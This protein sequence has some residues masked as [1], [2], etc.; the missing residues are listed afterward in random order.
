MTKHLLRYFWI[1]YLVVLSLVLPSVN[2]ETVV[3]TVS[4][5]ATPA[6]LS[7]TVTPQW[8]DKQQKLIEKAKATLEKERLTW[9]TEEKSFPKKMEEID[10]AAKPVTEDLLKP[11]VEAKEAASSPVEKLHSERQLTKDHLEKLQ[12]T[13]QEQ[14]KQLESLQASPPAKLATDTP[15]K[16]SSPATAPPAQP[17]AKKH[18]NTSS[19]SKQENARAETA[20]TPAPKDEVKDKPNN[21]LAEPAVKPEPTPDELKAN[22]ALLQSAIDIQ[23]QYL[24]VL[25]EQYQIASQHLKLAIQWH[26]KLQVSIQMRQLKEKQEAIKNV[27]A[28]LTKNQESFQFQQKELPSQIARLETA[29]ITADA[30]REMLEKA[31]LDKET[32][33]IEIDNLKLENQGA[34]ANLAKQ[35]NDIEDQRKKLE[36]LRKTALPEP[37]QVEVQNQIIAGQENAIKLQE[38]RLELDKQSFDLAKQSLEQTEKQSQLATEWHQKLQTVYQQREQQF[39]E[40]QVQQEQQRHLSHALELRKQ[41]EQLPATAPVTQRELL[42]VQIQEAKERAEQV[43]RQLQFKHLEA[44]LQQWQTASQQK[45]TETEI[46]Q[47]LSSLQD[48]LKNMGNL[49]VGLKELQESLDSKVQAF[50]QQLDVVKKKGETL[51]EETLLKYNTQSQQILT[52]LAGGLR[53]ELN[54]IP[55]LRSKGEDLQKQ[56]ESTYK[57]TLGQAL[58]RVRQLP[59]DIA[60]WRILFEEGL[61]P[62]PNLFV[63]QVQLTW[64]GFAQAFQQTTAQNW[65]SFSVVTL[66]WLLFLAGTLRW[67]GG[68]TLNTLNTAKE[69]SFAAYGASL[70]IRLLQRNVGSIAIAGVVM[71]LLWLTKPTW[72]HSIFVLTLVTGWLAITLL[73]NGVRLLLA[74]D[75]LKIADHAKLSWELQSLFLFLGI[76]GVITTLIHIDVEEYVLKVSL[77][78]SDLIDT[79]F[80]LG[81]SLTV[82]PLLQFRKVMLNAWQSRNQSSGGV[83]IHLLTLIVPLLILAVALLGLI[84]YIN[85][86]WNIAKH[87]S[88]FLL[89]LIGWFIIWGLVTDAINWWK[90]VATTR[91]NNALWTESLIPLVHKILGIALVIL[92]GMA[93]SW[94]NGWYADVAVRQNIVGVLDFSLLKLGGQAITVGDVLL[95]IFALWIV[96]WLGGWSRQVTYQ[97]VYQNVIDTGV[98]HSLSVFTQYAV[99]LVGLLVTLNIIGINL[100]TLTVFAGAVGV[101]IGF[102]LQNVINNFVSG[103]LLLVERPLR[104]GD[105]V[106]ISS[107]QGKVVEIGIRS[108]TLETPE[109]QAVIVP[110]SAVISQI[111]INWTRDNS[112]RR[113]SL[114]V[115][116]DFDDNPQLVQDILTATLEEN[117]EVRKQPAFKVYLSEYTDLAMKFRIDYFVDIR[118]TNFTQVNST[119][120]I[121]IWERFRVAGI[122][123]SRQH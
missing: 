118:K 44:Q 114:Y 82:L 49:F 45:T 29:Q 10:K 76:L 36:T 87:L 50:E 77:T 63:Q 8:L 92:A 7:T 24:K 28:E 48:L 80:M 66:L 59:K 96:F 21:A 25:D 34:E 13:L 43:K 60:G 54:K 22:I 41:L 32:K 75:S 20:K 74:D 95:G 2:A 5:P 38:Q 56:L 115:N 68:N 30:L 90:S 55:T 86:G 98:R 11:A 51:S 12:Q 65:Q 42:K 23:K 57:E 40:V 88:L 58:F 61:K 9:K 70:G 39:L 110:N 81:L 120:L 3:T 15:A 33:A 93:F 116:V 69:R 52:S 37:A 100:T 121:K 62:L 112:L 72:A 99:I 108:L 89:V 106:N 16:P 27:K 71:L 109:G 47:T 119:L 31:A 1:C 94:L 122:K 83:V 85:L 107:N 97:S 67:C 6:V 103:I 102:G 14:Q 101:G 84:G 73:L 104:T 78:T 17:H 53:T 111:F 46:Y 113:I 91:P 117:P 64:Q 105:I 4:N 18:E 123:I 26:D 35:K 19:P 79:L